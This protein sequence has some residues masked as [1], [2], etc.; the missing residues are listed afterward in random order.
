MLRRPKR[1]KNEAVAPKEEEEENEKKEGD[2]TGHIFLIVQRQRMREILP[3]LLHTP[4]WRDAVKR[5][6]NFIFNSTARKAI[7][8]MENIL[9]QFA[10][11]V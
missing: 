2:Y 10:C 8:T 6:D 3:P 9:I 7:F 4:S 11:S 1:S 5:R